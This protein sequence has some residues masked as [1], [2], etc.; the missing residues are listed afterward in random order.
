[1]A[2]IM[3]I[4]RAV[5]GALT[6]IGYGLLMGADPDNVNLRRFPDLI[7]T[8]WLGNGAYHEQAESQ[9]KLAYAPPQTY[10]ASPLRRIGVV[11]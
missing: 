11:G 3:A 10:N 6:G 1:M 7:G 9:L 8:R 2:N 5:L 4:V